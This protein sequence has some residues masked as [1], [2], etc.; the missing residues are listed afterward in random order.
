V[1]VR[2]PEPWV[3]RTFSV[4]ATKKKAPTWVEGGTTGTRRRRQVDCWDVGGRTD[5]IQWLKRFPKTGL[6][7]AW[8]EQLERDF[9]A[10][11]P[12]DLDAWRFV[13]PEAPERPWVP[14]VFELYHSERCQALVQPR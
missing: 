4:W 11:L 7:Q 14:T 8:K 5:G 3:P 13:A 2:P 10:G 1:G 12:F 9:A 6:A